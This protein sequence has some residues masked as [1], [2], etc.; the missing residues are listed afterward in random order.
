LEGIA[1]CDGKQRIGKDALEISQAH[2]GSAAAEQAVIL[3]AQDEPIDD[4]VPDKESKEEESRQQEQQACR[5]TPREPDQRMDTGCWRYLDARQLAI[6]HRNH[7]RPP[8][9]QQYVPDLSRRPGRTT[10]RSRTSTIRRAATERVGTR[11]GM[12]RGRVQ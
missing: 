4:R 8:S 9:S 5:M 10:P 2:P 6:L 3:K 11:S 12:I 7:D 1:P